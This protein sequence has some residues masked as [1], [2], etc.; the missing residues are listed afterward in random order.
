MLTNPIPTGDEHPLYKNRFILKFPEN[1]NIPYYLIRSV[2]L[3]EVTINENSLKPV[4]TKDSDGEIKNIRTLSYSHS[5]LE[6][7]L[8]NTDKFSFDTEFIYPNNAY[9]FSLALDFLSPT[10]VTVKSLNFKNSFIRKIESVL[11]SY[12][13]NDNID[14]YPILTKLFISFSNIEHTKV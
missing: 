1:F 6:V 3:P 12:D 8:Y 7:L 5:E 13:D 4:L 11:L 10:G 9:K 2:K 14:G